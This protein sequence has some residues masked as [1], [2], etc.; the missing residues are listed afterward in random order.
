MRPSRG[1]KGYSTPPCAATA[2][3]AECRCLV[4]WVAWRGRGP[5]G[6][7][8]RGNAD[9]GEDALDPDE[10]LQRAVAS[11]PLLVVR[12]LAKLNDQGVGKGMEWQVRPPPPP[13]PTALPSPVPPHTP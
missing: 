6:G 3:G 1:A 11:F 9:G 2:P 5:A 12:L 4:E 10:D 7:H 8:T 13:P